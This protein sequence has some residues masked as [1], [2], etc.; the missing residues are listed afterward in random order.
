[1][2]PSK[3]IHEHQDDNE[4]QFQRHGWHVADVERVDRIPAELRAAVVD[5]LRTVTDAAG[6]D[7]DALAKLEKI[8]TR[9]KSK[10]PDPHHRSRAR[11]YWALKKLSETEDLE[12]PRRIN[13]QIIA[14]RLT[15]DEQAARKARLIPSVLG[16]VDP[17][18]RAL[19]PDFVLL[20]LRDTSIHNLA[21]SLSV[22]C[23]AFDDAPDAPG[24]AA[25]L[26]AVATAQR[27]Y[28]RSTSEPSRKEPH[29][30]KKKGARASARV[31]TKQRAATLRQ[32]DE[33][34]S[35]ASLSTRK[36]PSV[37]API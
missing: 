17:R 16:R 13:G 21:A 4:H 12:A 1:M 36:R 5:L 18:F 32:C 28:L 11:V 26:D 19:S 22:E 24:K 9:S 29:T 30:R 2:N 34:P 37:S 27:A 31:P 15:P 23:G 8:A 20:V 7:P 3:P 6:G 33:S 35:P 14:V 10:S 25:K